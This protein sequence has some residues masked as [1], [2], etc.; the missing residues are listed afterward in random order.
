M[1]IGS[2]TNLYMYSRCNPVIQVDP[3]GR[4]GEPPQ[5]HLI[6]QSGGRQP[7]TA[8]TTT[9]GFG[10][11]LRTAYQ[12]WGAQ[13]GWESTD[14]GHPENK[15]FSLTRAGETTNVFPQESAENRSLGAST[16]KS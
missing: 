14:V 5:L 12:D 16:E 2:G 1:G 6:Q 11:D 3:S 15:P 10:Q 4:A 13:W 9:P 7:V 8:T